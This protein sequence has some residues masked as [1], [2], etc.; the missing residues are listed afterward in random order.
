M[1]GWFTARGLTAGYGEAPVIQDV[2]LDIGMGEVVSVVGANGAGKTTLV[3]TLC[4]LLPTKSGSVQLAGR[5]LSAEPAHERVTAGLVPVL[6]SRRLF[7]ELTVEDTLRLGLTYGRKRLR[8]GGEQRFTHEDVVRLFPVLADLRRAAVGVLSGGQQQMVALAKALLLQ[9]AVL[10]LDEM[11]TGLA[12]RLLEEIL[13]V[14]TELKGSGMSMLVIEQSVGVA[15]EISDRG[16]VLDLGHVVASGDWSELHE[17][18]LA[19]AYL[20]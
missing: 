13:E 10:V 19:K 15:A 12:P 3:N 1:T 11:S 14:L 4:G 9:P 7:P 2:D 20:G 8:R 17:D 5:D 6:E 18:E 16:Y